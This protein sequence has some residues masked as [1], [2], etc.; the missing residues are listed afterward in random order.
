MS[1]QVICG[2]LHN[3]ARILYLYHVMFIIKDGSN[4]HGGVCIVEITSFS[5]KIINKDGQ[6]V[7]S[8]KQAGTQFF[9]EPCSF[10]Y[11]LLAFYNKYLFAFLI[12][13]ERNVHSRS[14]R[15]RKPWEGENGVHNWSCPLTGM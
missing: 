10:S 4:Y 7:T 12:I 11:L 2:I 15:K 14:S 8:G 9:P 3:F 6:E 1:R 5:N 13:Q